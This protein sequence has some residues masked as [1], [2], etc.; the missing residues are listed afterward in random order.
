MCHGGQEAGDELGRETSNGMFLGVCFAHN[1]STLILES[2]IPI[3]R[4]E[5]RR[6]KRFHVFPLLAA[7]APIL[8]HAQAV[9]RTEIGCYKMHFRPSLPHSRSKGLI[10]LKKNSHMS[11]LCHHFQIILENILKSTSPGLLHVPLEQWSPTC[12]WATVIAIRPSQHKGKSMAHGRNQPGSDLSFTFLPCRPGLEMPGDVCYA[13]AHSSCAPSRPVGTPD[14]D[15][16]CCSWHVQRHFG[17]D[18]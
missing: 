12:S 6:G 8:F 2:H 14:S 13:P 10:F 11:T 4:L 3:K 15:S 18:H 5:K 7:T 1:I 17:W 9:S 16:R